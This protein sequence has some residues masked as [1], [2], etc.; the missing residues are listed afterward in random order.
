MLGEVSPNFPTTS[1]LI[2]CHPP[3]LPHRNLPRNP[4][5][6]TATNRVSKDAAK[7][8]QAETR[9][10]PAQDLQSHPTPGRDARRNLQA[11][12][13]AP[14]KPATKPASQARSQ[15]RRPSPRPPP[16]PTRK[17]RRPSAL[18]WAKPAK[19]PKASKGTA[20]A[21]SCRQ[22]LQSQQSRQSRR[23]PQAPDRHSGN[24]GEN[25]RTHQA[26]Q[27]A[28]LSHLRRHQRDPA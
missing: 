10:N 21:N 14:A 6:T 24:P 20:E 15:A 16:N 2:P 23:C 19:E 28:G 26:R 12:A 3:T 18:R 22:I 11:P 27:G 25:P 4:R 8:L 7:R 17:P 9:L 5:P 1:T 13:I